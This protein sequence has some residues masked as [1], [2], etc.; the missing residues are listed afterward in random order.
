MQ[1]LDPIQAP[2]NEGLEEKA[3][4][5]QSLN[6]F[7]GSAQNPLSP[8]KSSALRGALVGLI[9]L[10]LLLLIVAVTVL[11]TALARQLVASSG[12]FAQQQASLIVL[13]AGLAVALVVYIIAIVRTLRSVTAWQR[14]GAGGQAR[15]ALLALGFTGLVVLLPV[16]LMMVLPQSP[17]P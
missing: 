15:A 5:S 17:A 12:F 8:Y 1:R 2:H 3:M 13:V 14:G 16:V 6:T 9:P 7:N 10:G 4:S 11:L